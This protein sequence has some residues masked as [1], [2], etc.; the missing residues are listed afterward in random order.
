MLT[1]ALGG[2]RSGH[3]ESRQDGAVLPH[4]HLRVESAVDAGRRAVAVVVGGV[5]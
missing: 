3:V 5:G 2:G 4:R 1:G